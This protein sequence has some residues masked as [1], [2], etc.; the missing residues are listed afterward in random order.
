[1]GYEGIVLS[2]WG[3][4]SDRVNAL[5]AGLDLEMPGPSPA[6]DKKIVEAV[7]SGQLK[8]EILDDAVRRILRILFRSLEQRDASSVI[9]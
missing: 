3:A 2:D 8:E 7:K 1:M 9:E 5:S 6:N 4:T